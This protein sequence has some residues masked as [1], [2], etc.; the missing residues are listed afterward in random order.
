[1]SDTC[2]LHL[3]P[4]NGSYFWLNTT[5]PVTVRLVLS[6]WSRPVYN[7]Q[8]KFWMLP[9]QHDMK[10]VSGTVPE[11]TV[12]KYEGVEGFLR[13]LM[14]APRLWLQTH[15]NFYECRPG[16]E[17]SGS[18]YWSDTWVN[19]NRHP[20]MTTAF[21]LTMGR[22]VTQLKHQSCFAVIYKANSSGT[23]IL[24][25]LYNYYSIWVSAL[26]LLQS[27]YSIVIFIYSSEKW[28]LEVSTVLKYK[29]LILFRSTGDLHQWT[30][31]DC[32]WWL[33]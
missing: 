3:G 14:S 23:T 26:E 2:F 15:S 18:W 13:P 7:F 32:V 1:V 6:V 5:H 22:V 12:G 16:K 33:I 24:E 10:S 21:K 19:F 28:W 30:V 8:D 9:G 25:S 11:I 29:F 4:L 17:L 31:G 20:L 27:F